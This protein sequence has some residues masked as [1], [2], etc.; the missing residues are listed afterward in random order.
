MYYKYEFTSCEGKKITFTCTSEFAVHKQ[1][2]YIQM[3][4]DEIGMTLDA[5]KC[6]L[7]IVGIITKCM[8]TNMV[9]KLEVEKILGEE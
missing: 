6:I 2:D 9:C 7:E 5:R 8:S 3:T 4:E 1:K